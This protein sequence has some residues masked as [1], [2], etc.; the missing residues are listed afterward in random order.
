M[1]EKTVNKTGAIAQPCWVPLVTGKK[2]D[3]LP[4]SITLAINHS[5]N[6]QMTLINFPRQQNLCSAFHRPPWFTVS[7]ALV[8]RTS[9]PWAFSFYLRYC[10][11][12]VDSSPTSS[13]TTVQFRIHRGKQMQANLTENDPCQNF[14]CDGEKWDT[15]EVVTARL[16]SPLL[17]QVNYRCIL[18]LLR[19][20]TLIPDVTKEA[21]G[22]A[23]LG[24]SSKHVDFRLNTS[25]PGELPVDRCLIALEIWPG[26]ALWQTCPGQDAVQVSQICRSALQTDGSGGCW[27]APSSGGVRHV[28][29]W[30]AGYELLWGQVS[31]HWIWC[32]TDRRPSW[33]ALMSCLMVQG[34]SCRWHLIIYLYRTC[35][36]CAYRPKA[37]PSR[38]FLSSQS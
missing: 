6:E 12:Q 8:R 7:K 25:S 34:L 35:K 13:K 38:S 31:W 23:T 26:M 20:N 1:A 32:L 33:K 36:H 21:T 18:V 29:M 3:E 14:V 15:T 22:F 5:G 27:S 19:D 9:T 11:A 16:V 37:W 28:C 30:G 17:V 2:A 24:G 4:L 10:K